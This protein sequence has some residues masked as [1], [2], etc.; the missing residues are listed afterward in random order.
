MP[1]MEE[2]SA[3]YRCEGD[4]GSPL[5]VVEYRHVGHA[6]TE[7]GR[8]RYPGARRLALSTG[9]LVRYVDAVTF[10]VVDTGE[11]VRRCGRS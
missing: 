10:E 4:D 7:A 11:L 9:Q 1:L 2:E 6:N 5:T 3:R 8:R